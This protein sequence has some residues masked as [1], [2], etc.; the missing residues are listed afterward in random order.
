MRKVLYCRR[1]LG[2]TNYTIRFI[3]TER[4]GC[5]EWANYTGS[6]KLREAVGS[7]AGDALKEALHAMALSA[8]V[9]WHCSLWWEERAKARKNDVI[10]LHPLVLRCDP[11]ENICKRHATF[12]TLQLELNAMNMQ[13]AVHDYN[14]KKKREDS[15]S[16]LDS[17]PTVKSSQSITPSDG[18][19]ATGGPRIKRAKLERDAQIPQN[20]LKNLVPTFEEPGQSCENDRKT[21]H[22]SNTTKQIDERIASGNDAES[23]QPDN[24]K[25]SLKSKMHE[26]HQPPESGTDIVMQ[27]RYNL[28][29]RCRSV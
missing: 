7:I 28:R 22:T 18:V 14:I 9:L 19:E 1:S 2:G 26:V 3:K 16:A 13:R 5:Q 29:K 20:S 15:G 12:E 4:N 21:R 8:D 17:A 11:E 6:S 23:I 25:T 27:V 24:M 10:R